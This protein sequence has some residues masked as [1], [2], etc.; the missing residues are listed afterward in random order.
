MLDPEWRKAFIDHYQISIK[1]KERLLEELNTK[2]PANKDSE[3]HDLWEDMKEKMNQ[4]IDLV[5]GILLSF[6]SK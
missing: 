6:Q 4:D 2:E 5:K 3:D 1:E